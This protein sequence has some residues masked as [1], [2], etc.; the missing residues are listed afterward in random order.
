MTFKKD[1]CLGRIISTPRVVV[2][3]DTIEE[4]KFV[5]ALS[6]EETVPEHG[7]IMLCSIDWG[8]AIYDWEVQ[9]GHLVINCYQKKTDGKRK[10]P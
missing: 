1:L 5:V 8:T 6:P 10:I 3:S 9:Y 4:M 2:G 7:C